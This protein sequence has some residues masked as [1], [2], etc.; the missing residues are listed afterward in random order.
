MK[1]YQIY[2]YLL[3]GIM[4]CALYLD[5]QAQTK[6]YKIQLAAY[7][8]AD[9]AQNVKVGEVEG[10]LYTETTAAGVTRVILGFYADRASAQHVL[11]YVKTLGYKDAF[12]AAHTSPLPEV[13]KNKQTIE[14]KQTVVSTTEKKEKPELLLM[15]D[16]EPAKK[17]DKTP[18][19][20]ASP[21]A[22]I[23]QFDALF[24]PSSFDIFH[25]NAYDPLATGT[26][27]INQQF[28][29][30]AI[31]NTYESL[32]IDSTMPKG[33]NFYALQKFEL[34]DN[35]RA[36]LIRGGKGQYNNDNFI[37]M[38]VYDKKTGKFVA[39]QKLSSVSSKNGYNKRQSWLVDLD[40]DKAIDVLTYDT[41]E[42][43]NATGAFVVTNK[44][45]AHVWLN[46][47]YTQAR[48]VDEAAVKAKLGVK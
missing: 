47:V 30:T 7:T 46:N 31:A 4:L 40:N 10:N 33:L 29:G 22:N 1:S 43:K 24:A 8:N 35:H 9:Y 48:I 5:V 44:L 3:V 42:A 28:K 36:Y 39:T 25:V 15:T 6:S 21:K 17:V 16:R 20:K 12:V 38:R 27:P 14:V 2:C 13:A 19:K 41:N 37:F 26:N 18:A 34:A 11:D 45:T 23:V 32:F